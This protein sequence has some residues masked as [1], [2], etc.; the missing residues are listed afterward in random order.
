MKKWVLFCNHS[1][2]GLLRRFQSSVKGFLFDS[3][4]Q[5]VPLIKFYWW[6]FM[7]FK[8]NNKCRIHLIRF[9]NIWV[10]FGGGVE[11]EKEGGGDYQ[12]I[13]IYFPILFTKTL[14]H[15]GALLQCS[16][17]WMAIPNCTQEILVE[18]DRWP[19]TG[20]L[21]CHRWAQLYGLT[22]CSDTVCT[23]KHMI[24]N[25]SNKPAIVYYT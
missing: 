6:C 21:A 18:G 11:R 23:D 15:K 14:F 10:F 17:V 13:S 4:F 1:W 2:I 5:N 12:N 3:L 7:M 25:L 9:F 19:G 20:S 8:N 16:S 24:T 22:L